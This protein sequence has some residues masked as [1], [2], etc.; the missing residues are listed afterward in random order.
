MV[1]DSAPSEADSTF[2]HASNPPTS[3]A[4]PNDGVETSGIVA[5]P[6]AVEIEVV[7]SGPSE[8]TVVGDAL[9]G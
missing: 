9:E 2:V 7:T 1:A 6:A 4:V 8:S 5:A 3:P